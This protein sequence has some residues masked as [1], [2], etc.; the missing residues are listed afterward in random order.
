M[1]PAVIFNDLFNKR[2]SIM[3]KLYGSVDYHNLKFENVG[4]TKIVHNSK[5]LYCLRTGCI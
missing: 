3:S 5:H 1:T 2:K 4:P